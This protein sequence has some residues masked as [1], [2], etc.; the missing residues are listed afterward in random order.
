M[1]PHRTTVGLEFPIRLAPLLG[2]DRYQQSLILLVAV[3]ALKK[4][5]MDQRHRCCS[6]RSRE[7]YLYKKVHLLEALVAAYLTRARLGYGSHQFVEVSSS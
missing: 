6:I 2:A 4:M 3:L 5:I 1:Y 7:L